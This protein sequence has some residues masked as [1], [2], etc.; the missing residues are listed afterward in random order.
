MIDKVLDRRSKKGVIIPI[1]EDE[2]Q[3]KLGKL[4]N[5]RIMSFLR[6]LGLDSPWVR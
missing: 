4:L 5:K 1:R 2:P 6:P 3:V